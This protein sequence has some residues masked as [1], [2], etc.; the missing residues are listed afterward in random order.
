MPFCYPLIRDVVGSGADF[1]E[2]SDRQADRQL[3]VRGAVVVAV[4][5]GRL[6]ER[7]SDGA[8]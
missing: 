2:Q 7:V 8:I 1:V 4:L 3:D 6:G 5:G